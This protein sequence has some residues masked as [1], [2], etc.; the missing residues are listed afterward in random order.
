M[1]DEEVIEIP[2][3]KLFGTPAR[4]PAE[5]REVYRK[6]L[7]IAVEKGYHPDAIKELKRKAFG[8]DMN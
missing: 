6:A 2:I 1:E 7:K 5:C 8:P 4:T 3:E